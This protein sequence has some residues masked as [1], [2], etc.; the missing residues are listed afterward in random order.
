MLI[1]VYD[2]LE[3][4]KMKKLKLP[5]NCVFC[6]KNVHGFIGTESILV[7]CCK[8][9]FKKPYVKNKICTL[10]NVFYGLAV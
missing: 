6:K 9:C 1:L 3:E 8:I 4:E 7:P 10:H 5:R 2:L